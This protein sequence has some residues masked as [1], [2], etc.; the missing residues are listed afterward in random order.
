MRVHIVLGAR[1]VPATAADA[2][3][4]NAPLV[5]HGDVERVSL[6]DPAILAAHVARCAEEAGKPVPLIDRR[7]S[8]FSTTPAI[9]G[10][11]LCQNTG[12]VVVYDARLV[13]RLIDANPI[14]LEV[15]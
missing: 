14:G 4:G 3:G 8:P 5:T 11:P 13:R 7:G 12:I 9:P 1:P 15:G 10:V 6:T 2:C